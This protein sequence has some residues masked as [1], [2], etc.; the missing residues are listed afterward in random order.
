MSSKR[1]VEI[2]TAGCPLCTDAVKLVQSIAGDGDEIVV[3]DMHD[4]DA[5]A[6]AKEHRV[7][8][9]PAVIV[10]GNPA[11]CCAGVGDGVNEQGL[12]N[13]GIGTPL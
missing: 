5:A 1:K 6:R 2:F 12:R 10:N 4:P 8:R 3:L 9:L 7:E 11:D 13:R